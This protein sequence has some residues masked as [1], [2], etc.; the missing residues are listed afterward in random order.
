MVSAHSGIGL[1]DLLDEIARRLGS[2]SPRAAPWLGM[3]AAR[4]R[5]SLLQAAAALNRAE[6]SAGLSA[7]GDELLAI[8]LRDAL[9]HLGQ[10]VGAVYTDDLLDRIFSKF[11]IGK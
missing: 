11:C 1:D 10:I 7:A 5:E 8:D 3:T 6:E 9:D 4:C 2:P